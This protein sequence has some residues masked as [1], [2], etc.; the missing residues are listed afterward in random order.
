MRPCVF[1]RTECI[2]APEPD[3][4]IELDLRAV[5]VQCSCSAA[6]DLSHCNT[7]ERDVLEW[8]IISVL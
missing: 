4:Q 5:A 2:L 3:A 7:V 1:L 6:A 8:Q